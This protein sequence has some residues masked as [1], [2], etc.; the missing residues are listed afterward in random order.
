MFLIFVAH[1]NDENFPIYGMYVCI[2]LS[3]GPFPAFQMLHGPHWKPGGAC[4]RRC[5]C[6]HYC[7]RVNVNPPCFVIIF[8]V[9]ICDQRLSLMACCLF[10]HI[11][12]FH[13]NYR[14]ILLW[15][16]IFLREFLFMRIVRVKRWSHEFV[17][18]KFLS[19]HIIIAM[20]KRIKIM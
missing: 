6:V 19:H 4:G 11:Y 5:I 8:I 3:P 9:Q 13:C 20:H 14:V 18:H 10:V 17:L 2:S 12:W 16:N 7:H 1:T 15:N